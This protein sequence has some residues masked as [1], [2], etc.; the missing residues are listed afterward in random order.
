MMRKIPQYW[1]EIPTFSQ[2]FGTEFN[3]SMY[4][5]GNKSIVKLKFEWNQNKAAKNIGK[6]RASFDEAATI[7]DDPMFITLTFKHQKHQIMGWLC[8][9]GKLPGVIKHLSP[10]S[11]NE[12]KYF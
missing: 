11:K 2:S 6:H 9:R 10:L 4:I 8:L 1:R 12:S 7:F 5:G 3:F